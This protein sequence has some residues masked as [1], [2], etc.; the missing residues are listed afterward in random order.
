MYSNKQGILVGVK[1][2]HEKDAILSVL[3]EDSVLRKGWVKVTK[4]EIGQILSIKFHD[5]NQGIR[6]FLVEDVGQN[7]A[8]QFW[9]QADKLG[10]LIKIFKELE[11]IPENLIV[12]NLYQ[13]L[14]S[15]I[16]DMKKG[17]SNLKIWDKI[18]NL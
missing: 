13:D 14:I 3:F 1:R 5:Q 11:K 18:K 17:V 4:Y 16:V 15:Y 7:I 9:S 10:D 6:N 8:M 2:Y 12:D